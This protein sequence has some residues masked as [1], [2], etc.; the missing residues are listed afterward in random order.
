[1]IV[2]YL[3]LLETEADKEIYAKL[4]EETLQHLYLTARKYVKNDQDAEDAVHDGYLHLAEHFERY[5]D[6]SFDCLK[7]LMH[8]T[9]VNAAK[10]I[11][12]EYGKKAYFD[13]VN[14][15]K[16]DNVEYIRPSVLDDIIKQYDQKLI[17]QAMKELE[18]DER[19]ILNL[20]YDLNLKPREIGKLLHVSSDVIR[21]K[22]LKSRKKLAKILEGKEYEDLR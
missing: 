1:M 6:Q 13:P 12:R 3:S 15:L 7:S 19:A 17:A 16:E 10:D 11:A 22:A 2:C 21:K 4:Y 18:E 20:Q 8:A 9:V 14:G 5:R